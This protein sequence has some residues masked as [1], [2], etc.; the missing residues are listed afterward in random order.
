[1]IFT[2]NTEIMNKTTIIKNHQ[3]NLGVLSLPTQWFYLE[4]LHI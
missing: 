2:Y 4:V 1:M 3:T